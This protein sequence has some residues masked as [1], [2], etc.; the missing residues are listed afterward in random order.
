MAVGFCSNVLFFRLLIEK[1]V[2]GISTSRH[3]ISGKLISKWSVIFLPWTWGV[4]VWSAKA[5]LTA[6][7]VWHFVSHIE[8]RTLRNECASSFFFD[9]SRSRS[10]IKRFMS[11]T[12][13]IKRQA[14]ANETRC[15]Y[16]PSG[17]ASR[18]R[19][20]GTSRKRPHECASHIGQWAAYCGPLYT[21]MYMRLRT[22][23][24]AAL[25]CFHCC[26]FSFLDLYISMLL[27]YKYRETAAVLI[28][29]S[30]ALVCWVCAISSPARN[31]L[32][33]H[34]VSQHECHFVDNTARK[35]TMNA[36]F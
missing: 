5:T 16:T 14:S 32:L 29:L 4:T 2:G 12:M 13:T 34:I 3:Q 23:R 15:P 24:E 8:L 26:F 33:E 20:G 7:G 17:G 27:S 28:C 9:E 25:H 19:S 35:K 11:R 10:S 36:K 1:F 21:I 30:C 18:K 22:S 31:S 6:Y